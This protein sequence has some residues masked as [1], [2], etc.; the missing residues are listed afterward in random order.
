MMNKSQRLSIH[1]H[2][3]F[4]HCASGISSSLALRCSCSL[5]TVVGPGIEI[6]ALCAAP[7]EVPT[8][9]PSQIPLSCPVAPQPGHPELV[10][11]QASAPSPT[12]TR[13]EEHI[14]TT[15]DCRSRAPAPS[16]TPTR[17]E[18]L[19]GLQIVRVRALARRRAPKRTSHHTCW[20]ESISPNTA[21]E[22]LGAFA[23]WVPATAMLL[24]PLALLL[25]LTSPWQQHHCSL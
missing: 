8:H 3:T 24:L 20:C 23:T 21:R 5:L 7:P 9:S 19:S 6:E 10:E 13:A 2:R 16:P 1:A 14:A 17:A 22:N 15:L 18:H 12:P 4:G 11:L 25:S